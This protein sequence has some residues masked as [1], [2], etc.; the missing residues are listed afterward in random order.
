MASNEWGRVDDDGTVYVRTGD[1]ERMVGQFPQGSAEEA[2]RFFTERYEALEV[3]VGLLEERIGARVLSPDEA[4]DSVATVRKQ[5][6]DAAAVGDLAALARR[7]DSLDSRIAEQREARRAERA[8]QREQARGAKERIVGEAEE[9][10]EGTDWRHG[11]DRLRA[12]L[13]E[14]KSLPR[15]DKQSDDALWRR[16]SIART[17]HT[18]ARKAHFAQQAKQREAA[19]E[20]KQRLAD[21]AERLADSTDWGATAGRYKELMR[22]WKAAGPAPRQQ[23][24][25]LWQRFRGAQDR[26]FAARD[27]ARAELDQEYAAN[28][29]V[30]EQLL[31]EAEALLPVTD[32]EHA[33]HAFHRIAERWDAAGKV[34]RDRVKEMEGRLRTVEKA[35]RE[36]QQAQW[37]QTDPEKSAR[38]DDMV[39]QLV[40]GIDQL[41]REVTQARE[42]GKHQRA[43][44]LEQT[45]QAR[46]AFLETARQAS[47]DYSGS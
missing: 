42:A 16:F 45:L 21:E 25:R 11:A 34:P 32:V 13:E 18:K 47:Q 19:Q 3:E 40:A 33:R 35:I 4:R 37:Q 28:A 22:D 23:D 12:L 27:A 39:G 17:T 1:G 7:L 8:A 15:L 6:S 9:I 24:E 26:F 10:A 2:L 38:A 5:V 43:E 29:E 30:K 36:G 20:I 41:E 46:R 44:E 14:W 31:T